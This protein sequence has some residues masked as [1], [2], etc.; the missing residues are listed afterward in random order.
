MSFPKSKEEFDL[1]WNW[2][3]QAD[4]AATGNQT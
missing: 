2:Q 1:I 4:R 3:P